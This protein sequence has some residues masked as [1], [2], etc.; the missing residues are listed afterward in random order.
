[1]TAA[2]VPKNKVGRRNLRHS[3]L[4]MRIINYHLSIQKMSLPELEA[5]LLM[6]KE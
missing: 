2:I 6:M 4:N 3:D 1:M 5:Q